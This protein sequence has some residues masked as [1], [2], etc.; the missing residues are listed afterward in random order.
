MHVKK[1]LLNLFT[2]LIFFN[3]P[4]VLSSDD[5]DIENIYYRFSTTLMPLIYE[6]VTEAVK[7]STDPEDGV[8]LTQAADLAYRLWKNNIARS[9]FHSF[10][11]SPKYL[12]DK[13][14]QSNKSKRL[15]FVSSL[16]LPL[17]PYAMLI[18]QR[19]SPT[20]VTQI[21]KMR[22][23]AFDASHEFDY[24]RPIVHQVIDRL[25]DTLG[26]V[27]SQEP[28]F[29]P[30]KEQFNAYFNCT[31]HD[32]FVMAEALYQEKDD[33]EEEIA[34][35]FK[36]TARKKTVYGKH[37]FHLCDLILNKPSSFVGVTYSI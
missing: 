4:L 13:S 1:T 9:S 30:V 17:Y 37:L 16:L 23:G 12:T 8:D 2:I 27:F 36:C 11:Q 3:C 35:Y 10:V 7:I 6:S 14:P 28:S 22:Q 20:W 29:S 24:Q 31:D 19:L 25:L 15:N 21:L 5:A 26:V 18:H 34:A 32:C 33:M